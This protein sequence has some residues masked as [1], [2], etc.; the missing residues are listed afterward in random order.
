MFVQIK[1]DELKVRF[2]RSQKGY[3]AF[4]GDI[5][6]NKFITQEELNKNQMT[7]LTMAECVGEEY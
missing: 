3:M 6:T 1:G 5:S 2:K 7:A 4:V